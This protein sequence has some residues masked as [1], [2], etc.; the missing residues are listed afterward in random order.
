M[1]QHAG[2]AGHALVRGHFVFRR[3]RMGATLR[4]R[5]RRGDRPRP[6]LAGGGRRIRRDLAGA[7][8][9]RDGRPQRRRGGAGGAGHAG[10]PPGRCHRARDRV[11]QR[12]AGR[13]G[14]ARP[15]LRPHPRPRPRPPLCRLPRRVRPDGA[16]GLSAHRRAAA[17]GRP[18]GGQPRRRPDHR[19]PGRARL[20][21]LLRRGHPRLV[22]DPAGDGGARCGARAVQR[23]GVR[24]RPAPRRRR[25][26]QRA[27]PGG[28]RGERRGQRR[29]PRRR[30]A[31]ARLHRGQPPVVPA[32]RVRPVVPDHRRRRP[33]R[34]VGAGVSA[35]AAESLQ[36][37]GH[38]GGE[39][40]P[41]RLVFLS[42]VGEHPGVHLPRRSG[43]SG[44]ARQPHAGRSGSLRRRRGARHRGA[45]ALP[46]AGGRPR[47]GG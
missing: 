13:S 34:R 17:S 33:Q 23:P 22:G 26:G 46:R 9:R 37:R 19:Q 28:V 24:G 12:I 41:R 3:R 36:L 39:R 14:E 44:G 25:R 42:P 21:E 43:H 6:R 47:R 27:H 38:R 1:S 7:A 8:R 10:A 32:D 11:R 18:G 30:R 35:L 15:R 5:R 31:R 29:R 45:P 2:G 16:V 40:Q 20:L 4:D